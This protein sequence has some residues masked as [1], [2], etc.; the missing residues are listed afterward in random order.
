MA[1]M[2]SPNAHAKKNRNDA[3]RK[4]KTHHQSQSDRRRKTADRIRLQR[5]PPHPVRTRPPR[6]VRR[7]RQAHRCGGAG[8]RGCTG[9]ACLSCNFSFDRST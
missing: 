2:K 7:E 9:G 8:R 5:T 4:R 1:E 6:P 3:P